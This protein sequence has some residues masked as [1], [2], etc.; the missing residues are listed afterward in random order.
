MVGYYPA[1]SNRA[2]YLF[3]SDYCVLAGVSQGEGALICTFL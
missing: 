1:M 2:H 3:T